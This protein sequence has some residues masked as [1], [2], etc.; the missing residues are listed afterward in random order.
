MFSKRDG[1]L[2]WNCFSF[3]G[4][5]CVFGSSFLVL[6]SLLF[7]GG[8][9]EG[10][11][12]GSLDP[13][14]LVI[15]PFLSWIF[16]SLSIFPF[17]PRPIRIPFPLPFVLRG[18]WF[19]AILSPCSFFL[20]FRKDEATQKGDRIHQICK[21]VE[22]HTLTVKIQALTVNTHTLAVNTYALTSQDKKGFSCCFTITLS[23]FFLR[24][25]SRYTTGKKRAHM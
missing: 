13:L 12:D 20:C 15:F 21:R 23:Q 24:Q 7:S 25:V 4:F 9:R 2:C 16:C 14:P 11:A 18:Y 10:C 17:C 1:S 3:F 19:V 22:T 5:F 8:W 6:R